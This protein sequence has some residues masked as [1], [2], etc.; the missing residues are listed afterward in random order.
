MPFFLFISLFCF[1]FFARYMQLLLSA[2]QHQ[3]SVCASASAARI[4][5]LYA[6]LHTIAEII[7]ICFSKQVFLSLY[8][9]PLLRFGSCIFST[10]F[11]N[12]STIRFQCNFGF[13]L[14]RALQCFLFRIFFG[15]CLLVFFSFPSTGWYIALWWVLVFGLYGGWCTLSTGIAILYNSENWAHLICIFAIINFTYILLEWSW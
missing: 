11:G 13:L 12:F 4:H 14:L 10:S 5:S 15:F 2:R 3:T 7:D 9:F 8:S 1:V 6:T